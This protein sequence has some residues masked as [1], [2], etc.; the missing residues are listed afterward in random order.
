MWKAARGLSREDNG[1]KTTRPKRPNTI[2]KR[3]I[4]VVNSRTQRKSIAAL[5]SLT[6]RLQDPRLVSLRNQLGLLQVNRRK[7]EILDLVNNNTYTIVVAATGTGKSTQLPQI[8][9]DDA[10]I[11][12]QGTNC[13]VVCVQP[14][15]IA[16]SSLAHRVAR[17]RN[18]PVGY[19]VGYHVR[20]DAQRARHRGSVT[21]C[22]TG[23]MLELLQNV[24]RYLDTISH[25]ILDEVHERDTGLDLLMLLLKEYIGERQSKG[26][27]A[28]KL[29]ITSATINVDLFASYFQ[30]TSH[31]GTRS[32]APHIDIPGH[33]FQVTRHHLNDL[34]KSL[35]E[36]DPPTVKM[37]LE[38]QSTALYL[39]G[40]QPPGESPSSDSVQL[41]SPQ[42]QSSGRDEAVSEGQ[43][44]EGLPSPDS[45]QSVSLEGSSSGRDEAVSEGLSFREPPSPDSAQPLAPEKSPCGHAPAASERQS[46]ETSSSSDPVQSVYHEKDPPVP[47]G[48]VCAAV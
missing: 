23:I 48:L 8:F 9:L 22:T 37:L 4:S 12:H 36:Y 33:T 28:P 19:S 29:I 5:G 18:E 25:I 35:D 21:Y 41:V 34:L 24:P 32:P 39:K 17:E 6:K 38:E 7:G 47:L 44:R 20:F 27:H 14:R 26:A 15:R 1:S 11:R 16:A 30:N 31:D 13:R 42:E 43:S 10:A 46:P 2:S 3:N 40:Y 45:A